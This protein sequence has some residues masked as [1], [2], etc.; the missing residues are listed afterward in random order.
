MPELSR[1]AR[2]IE[3]WREL[4]GY[5]QAE[6]SRRA[7]LTLTA[8][9]DILRDPTRS[10]RLRTLEQ[11]ARALE[12]SLWKL[13][14][15]PASPPPDSGIALIGFEEFTLEERAQFAGVAEAVTDGARIAVIGDGAG[16]GFGLT[17]GQRV[18]VLPRESYAGQLVVVLTT[19]GACQIRYCAP[20]LFIGFPPYA[21]PFHEAIDGSGLRV[22]GALGLPRE[23][24]A[25]FATLL[26]G[27]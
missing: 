25:R 10:P 3:H 24:M 23:T 12:I 27:I 17:P 1:I 7:N 22:V 5:S 21:A 18:A 11:L 9:N 26:A 4:R 16:I 8:V 13:I 14:E 6:L 19:T 20:P 15:G 2:N